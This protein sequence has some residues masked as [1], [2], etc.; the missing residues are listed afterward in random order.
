VS[1][2]TRKRS[3]RKNKNQPK[4]RTL[5]FTGSAREKSAF[6]HEL[7]DREETR[8]GGDG[9]PAEDAAPAVRRQHHY[10]PSFRARHRRTVEHRVRERKRREVIAGYT[11]NVVPIARLYVQVGKRELFFL[12]TSGSVPGENSSPQV[13]RAI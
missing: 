11:I 3:V 6:A 7:R 1:L 8:R 4:C 9:P 2:Q 5:K 13:I 12:S 10:R